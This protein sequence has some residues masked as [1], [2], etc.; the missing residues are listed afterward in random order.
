VTPE[1]YDLSA[2]PPPPRRFIDNVR[3]FNEGG[4]AGLET[5]RGCGRPCI[6]CVEPIAK[7]RVNRQRLPD[8]I[9]AECRDL[10]DQGIDVIHLCDSEFNLPPQH[11]QAVCEALIRSGIAGSLRWY[12]YAYPQY[13]NAELAKTMARAGCVGI[14]FGVDHGAAEM[15]RRL[16]RSYTPGDIPGVL[17]A[18]KAAGITI[19]CDM[20]FGGPGETRTSIAQA[21]DFMRSLDVDRVG[22]SCGVRVYPNTPLARLVRRQGPLKSNPNLHGTLENNEDLLEP[23]FYVS[24]ALDGDIHAIVAELVDGDK[25]FLHAD[26]ARLDGNYNYNDNTVLERAIRRGERGAYWDILRRIEEQTPRDDMRDEKA[27]TQAMRD[28]E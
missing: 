26:P 4:Q 13:F 7:G 25:R 3:Y 10:L 19:M 20:L 12:T 8:S 21:L 14:N 16:G 15:L 9:V 17:D 11:A 2:M 6:Y 22:L 5:K 24:A 1:P 23:I 28:A 27:A 18:C